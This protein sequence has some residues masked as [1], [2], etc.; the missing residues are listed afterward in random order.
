MPRQRRIEYEG[1]LYH[2]LSRGKRREAI[3]LDD[4][5]RQDC[6]KTLAEAIRRA[7][8]KRRAWKEA[9]RRGQPKG[10]GAKMAQVARL[11]RETT[12]TLGN[13]VERLRRETTMKPE[14]DRQ[15]AAHGKLALCLQPAA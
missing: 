15:A 12:L 13:I 3:F 8:M 2:A 6:L 7:E 11:R 1:S 4:A 5:D 9:E 10:D 14:V